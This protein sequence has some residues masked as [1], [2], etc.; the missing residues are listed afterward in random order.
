MHINSAKHDAL[1]SHK[2]RK[3]ELL[4]VYVD[5]LKLD[6]ML[7]NALQRAK[8]LACNNE[9]DQHALDCPG[10]SHCLQ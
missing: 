6:M 1:K 5:T 9:I 3:E 4:K 10:P 7:N 8:C 2:L